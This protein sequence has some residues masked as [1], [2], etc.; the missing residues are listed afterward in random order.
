MVKENAQYLDTKKKLK[1][2]M[3][4]ILKSEGKMSPIALIDAVKFQNKSEE[5]ETRGILWAL[6]AE[7]I[8]EFSPGFREISIRV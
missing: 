3:T 7:G 2:S 1:Q 4:N 6:A 8:F 5:Y